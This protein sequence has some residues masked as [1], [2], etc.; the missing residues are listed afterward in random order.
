MAQFGNGGTGTAYLQDRLRRMG[1]FDLLQAI[2]RLEISTYHAAEI[3]GIVRRKPT[4]G[5]NDN[6]AKRRAFAARSLR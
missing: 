1:R 6:A 4:L 5:M 2:A 3:A